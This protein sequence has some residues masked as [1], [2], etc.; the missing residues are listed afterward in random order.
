MMYRLQ[1]RS[2]AGYSTMVVNQTVDVTTSIAGIRW[3]ELR[4]TS[5][6]W[7]LYQQATYAPSDGNSRWMGSIAMDSSGNMALGYSVSGTATYPSIRY[8]G[9]MKND[10][11]NQMTIAERGIMVGGGSS[12][13]ATN[14]RWGDYSALSCDP[15][16]RGTYWYTQEYFATTSSAGWRT[17]IASFKWK[18]PPAVSTTMATGITCSGATLNGSVTPNGAATTYHFDWG[19][20]AAYGFTTTPASAGSGYAV[21]NVSAPLT[22]LTGGTTYHYRLV[23]TS[24]DGTTNGSDMTFIPCAAAVVTTAATAITMVSATSGGNVT[25][26]GGSA[27]TARGVCWSTAINPTISD[28]HTT[29]GASTGTYISLITGLNANTLY[30]VRAY[31]TNSNGTFYGSDLP[32]NTLCAVSSLPFSEAFTSTSIP[33]CWSQ[34]DHQGNAQVWQFGVITNQTPN[35]LLNGNYAFLNSGG[36]GAGTSQNADLV[37]PL[38]DCSAFTNVTLQ[39]NHY[40]K[41]YTGTSG[42]LSYTNDGGLTWNIIQTFTA[43]S[44][45]N[46]AAFSQVIAGAAGKP[47][48]ML[49]W[50]Y[51]GTNGYSWAIDDVSI[52]GTSTN[53][54]AVSPANQNVTAPAGTTPF[55]VTSNTSWTASSNQTWCTVT[56]SGTGNGTITASYSINTL[57]TPR[58]ATVTVTAS[59]APTNTVTVTQAGATPTLIVTPANQNVPFT[60]SGT[61]VFTVTSNTVWTVVSDQSWCNVTPSG[62]GN[63]TITASYAENYNSTPRVANITVTVASLAPMVVTVTQA[64]APS[65]AV[66]PPQQAV[67][68]SPPGTTAFAVTSNTNWTVSHSASWCNVAP[69]SSTGNGTITA[70]YTENP[71]I[72]SRIDTITVT[73]AGLPPIKVKVIQDA[74]LPTLVIQPLN[75]TVPASPPSYTNFTVTSN[76]SWTLVSDQTWCTVN[77]SGSG[78]GTI[79]A[80]YTQNT[81]TTDRIANITAAAPNL[82]PVI[83]T[84]TQA[85]TVPT[86]LVTPPNRNV[87]YLSGNTTFTVASNSP[88]S[89]A[90]D[91]SW[92]TVTPSGV[93]NGT[94]TANFIQNPYHAYRVANVRVTVAGIQA[95]LVTV[96]QAPSTVGIHDA[97]SGT[98]Q[99]IPNPSK[100]AFRI[101]TG[102]LKYKSLEVII[103]DLSGRKIT[104]RIC[105]EK[106]D[107][108]FDLSNVPKGSYLVKIK[109]DDIEVTQKLIMSH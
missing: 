88:W 91:S 28:N 85:G 5:G 86:L 38:I 64:A 26:D 73:A 76:T 25:T 33:G 24:P 89:A 106:P 13:D 34:V 96:T 3:Y 108:Q 71:N 27:V 32:F 47:Q 1:Y 12:T 99:L 70:A 104:S 67:S 14:H 18:N 21:N 55:S 7:S 42:T 75:Q 8:T 19:T 39:F 20:S 6:A 90:S 92:L 43:T 17:R 77:P 52:I 84:L 30:H 40:F 15:V 37:S 93:G 83:V 61:S 2:F 29:N 31:A 4:K 100:G 11:L 65:L 62:S 57:V 50:N 81:A 69:V 63:G 23:A 95:Q 35:P 41:A 101:E 16:E 87:A 58:V 10:P 80:N 9:R 107:L 44:A 48:V 56:P 68:Y 105:H 53:T 72:V 45:T 94:I 51:T 49:R 102:E 54:L 82:A 109:M 98:I 103:M 79:I 36:Y 46:P 97:S 60:P 22:G 78:N 74:G 59:G 66:F